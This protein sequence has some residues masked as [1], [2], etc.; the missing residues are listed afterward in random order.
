MLYL[1][2]NN[3]TPL[4]SRN[5]VKLLLASDQFK[6]YFVICIQGVK[7]ALCWKVYQFDKLINKFQNYKA[8]NLG[9]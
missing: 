7:G 1:W 5:L 2:R 9:G 6:L 4:Y 3:N 8:N